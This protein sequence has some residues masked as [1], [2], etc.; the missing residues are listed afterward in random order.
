MRPNARY[1]D[2]YCSPPHFPLPRPPRSE[3]FSGLRDESLKIGNYSMD[4]QRLSDIFARKVRVSPAQRLC[5][6]EEASGRRAFQ[7]HKKDIL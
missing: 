7:L 2:R 1:V 5:A 4:E 6:V 3:L